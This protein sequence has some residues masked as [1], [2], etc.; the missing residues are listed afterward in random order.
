MKYGIADILI[1]SRHVF[2]ASYLSTWTRYIVVL[3]AVAK[4]FIPMPKT[5]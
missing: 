4:A 2:G 1:I 3:A 5:E